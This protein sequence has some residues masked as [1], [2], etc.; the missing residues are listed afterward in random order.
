MFCLFFELG[1]KEDYSGIIELLVDVLIGI[2]FCEYL[3]LNDVVIEISLILNWVDC[4]SI[5]GI[6]C[7]V[8][9]INCVEV[10]V[11]VIEVVFVIIVDKVVVKL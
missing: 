5:V 8:G 11:L 6:V 4:L 7:E 10:K 2:D 3:N 9:V 1:I